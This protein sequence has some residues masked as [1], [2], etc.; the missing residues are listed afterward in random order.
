MKADCILNCGI[1]LFLSGVKI[2]ASYQICD[3]GNARRFLDQVSVIPNS[4]WGS[5]F[6]SI[7][8]Y[9]ILAGILLYKTFHPVQNANIRLLISVGE[10]ALAALILKTLD[11]TYSGILLLVIMDLITETRGREKRLILLAVSLILYLFTDAQFLSMQIHLIPFRQYLAFYPAALQNFILGIRSLLYS[12]N[13]ILFVLYILF[14]MRSE[15]EKTIRI[16]NLNEQIN[17]A[18]QQLKLMNMRLHD[19][20][21]KA[22]KVTEVRERNRLAR[23]IHD[24]IGHALTGISVGVDA[25]ITMVEKSP[26]ATKQQLIKISEVAR[27]GIRDIRSSVKKLRPDALQNLSLEGALCKMIEEA[28]A[29]TNT[30]IA[31]DNQVHPLKFSP[32]EEDAVYRVVQE[33]ITN[34]IQHGKAKQIFISITKRE[35]W[36][37]LTVRDT[38]KGCPNVQKG[39]GLQHLQERIGLLGGNISY[40]GTDGFT[41]MAKIPIRWGE[42]KND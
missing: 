39:F 33:G 12:V 36:L 42:D 38:G 3:D 30:D 7:V 9:L 21:E 34:A 32:D 4:M 15:Q 18:N 17:S 13:L 23:E 27:Q 19:Y 16:R 31:F 24:S 41:V 26:K 1:L 28:G 5:A 2:R 29:V 37:T 11:F 35:K 8:G 25:C 22:E 10:V 14:L 20:A 6:L 40:Q